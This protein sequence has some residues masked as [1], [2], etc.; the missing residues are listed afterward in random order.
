MTLPR[1]LLIDLD[2]TILAFSLSAGPCWREVADRYAGSLDAAP[3]ELFAAIRRS[4][5][6]FWRDPQRDDRGRLDLVWARRRVVAA[7]LEDLG[8]PSGLGDAIADA[9]AALREQR[10]TLFPGAL[11]ALHELRARKV[12]LALVT[13]GSSASQRAKIERFELEP[14]FDAICVEEEQGAG[15]PDPRIFRAALAALDAAA[16]DAWMV[17][18]N[19]ER[20]VAGAQALGIHGIWC[21]WAGTGLPEATSVRPDR[22]VCGLPELLEGRPRGATGSP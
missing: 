3:D 4:A 19:L 18:D 1:A 2:D 9:Y 17:G 12:R 10:V 7:A 15:K 11:S 22:I 20:D 14:L 13:N 5:D 16:A 6:R 8:E 21:D